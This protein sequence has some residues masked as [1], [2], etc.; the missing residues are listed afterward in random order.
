MQFLKVL[1]VIAAL[2]AAYNFWSDWS[3]PSYAEVVEEVGSD[4][5]FVP[6]LPP[7]G[8]K[9]DMVYVMAP[10]N[11]PSD[12]AQRARQLAAGLESRGIPV[13]RSDHFRAAVSNPTAEER[14]ALKRTQAVLNGAIPMVV[15]NGVA[16]ANPSVDQVEA[17][18]RSVSK[19]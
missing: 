15:V 14:D 7:N 5:G 13:E 3:A 6:I 16:S 11:C 10:K 9:T 12:A 17:E 4:N 2:W 1:L 8:A 19:R 18:Y